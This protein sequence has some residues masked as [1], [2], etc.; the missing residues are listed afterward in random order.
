MLDSEFLVFIDDF[1]QVSVFRVLRSLGTVNVV[2][3]SQVFL[4]VFLLA[5]NSSRIV[6]SFGF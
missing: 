4:F 1:L 2:A 6:C 3:S 5:L